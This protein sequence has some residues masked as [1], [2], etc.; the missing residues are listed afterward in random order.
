M[1]AVW[2]AIVAVG[3]AVA[4]AA[5]FAGPA[6]AWAVT[7]AGYCVVPLGY[8]AAQAI[9]SPS[10]SPAAVTD[11]MQTAR[12][13]GMEPETQ[14]GAQGQQPP[15]IAQL[16]VAYAGSTSVCPEYWPAGPALRGCC[17]SG[18]WSG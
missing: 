6:G 5:A 14:L 11:G 8:A 12:V 1:F 10:S 9:S 7:G 3:C 15:P 18:G 2:L 16:W 13:T 4:A 17:L